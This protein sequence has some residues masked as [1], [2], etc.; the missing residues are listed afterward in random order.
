MEPSLITDKEN[1]LRDKML[2]WKNAKPAAEKLLVN[3]ETA[4]ARATARVDARAQSG[5][6]G[7]ADA[8]A[9]A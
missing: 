5:L 3:Y 4:A 2:A 1:E 7:L 9:M 8:A 6:D